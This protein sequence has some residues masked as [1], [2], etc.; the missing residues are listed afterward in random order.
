MLAVVTKPCLLPIGFSTLFRRERHNLPFGR[1]SLINRHFV[2]Q[3]TLD[4]CN[5]L[6]D[7]GK[8]F[9][10]SS[11]AD[12]CFLR[13]GLDRNSVNVFGLTQSDKSIHDLVFGF[14]S[15]FVFLFFLTHSALCSPFTKALCV[16]IIVHFAVKNNKVQQNSLKLS[17]K[18]ENTGHKTQRFRTFYQISSEI[19]R[20]LQK[21]SSLFAM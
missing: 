5:Y 9:I 1:S 20:S 13:D 2:K 10:K 4:M 18:N 21:C 19:E 7:V 3:K 6:V 12:L 16:Y 15:A 8:V 14:N 17:I 11:T